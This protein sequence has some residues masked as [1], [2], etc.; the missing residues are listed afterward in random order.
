MVYCL[1]VRSGMF[2]IHTMSFIC[3]TFVLTLGSI[4]LPGVAGPPGLTGEQGED[5]QK[6]EAGLKGRDGF[7]GLKGVAGNPVCYWLQI[8]FS[9]NGVY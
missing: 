6:G 7:N 1:N 4:G 2:A 5:G 9:K 8:I 3:E